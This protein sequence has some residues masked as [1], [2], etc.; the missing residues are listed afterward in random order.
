MSLGVLSV[1]GAVIFSGAWRALDHATLESWSKPLPRQFAGECVID[2]RC[3]KADCLESIMRLC[4]LCRICKGTR[5]DTVH[6]MTQWEASL[7]SWDTNCVSLTVENHKTTGSGRVLMKQVNVIIR[8]VFQKMIFPLFELWSTSRKM[9]VGIFQDKALVIQWSQACRSRSGV[10]IPYPITSGNP[11][12][13][14][15]F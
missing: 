6:Q 13:M 5:G 12:K 3:L 15:K 1:S 4:R 7:D 10:Y 11:A 9:A 2:T 14:R 8:L